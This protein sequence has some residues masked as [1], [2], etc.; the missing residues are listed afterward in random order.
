MYMPP[1]ARLVRGSGEIV[2]RIVTKS[3]HQAINARSTL[4]DGVTFRRGK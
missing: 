2:E 1:M 4:M 3:Q